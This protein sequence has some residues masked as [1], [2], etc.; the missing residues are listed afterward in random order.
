[1]RE[2]EPPSGPVVYKVAMK[3]LFLSFIVLG[4]TCL[5]AQTPTDPNKQ[6]EAPK[7]IH[8]MYLEEQADLPGKGPSAITGPEFD[9]RGLARLARVRELLAA[10]EVKTSQDFEEASSLFQHGVTA[11]DY[12]FAHVLAMEAVAKGDDG[13]RWLMAATLD[14]Y[15]QFIHQPQVFGTQFPLDPNVPHPVQDPHLGMYK[16]RT[17]EPYN[18]TLV[19]DAIRMDFCVPDRAQQTLNL[20]TFN[21]GTRPPGSAMRSPNC[22]NQP[23]KKPTP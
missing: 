20:A 3:Y 1:M 17:L 13:A 23:S 21:S 4:S 5:R 9:Q 16:G 6:P 12:L 18:D 7:S 10:G 2:N 19:P 15:L 11:D 14:R 8:Q 22:T